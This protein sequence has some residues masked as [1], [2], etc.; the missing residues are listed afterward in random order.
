MPISQEGF[1]KENLRNID[2]IKLV[3]IDNFG[4]SVFTRQQ[5]LEKM[6]EKYPDVPEGS[7]LMSDYC[8]NTVSGGEF[9]NEYR[10]LFRVKQGEYRLY[11]PYRDGK[12]KKGK[13]VID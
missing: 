10:F 9:S 11:D 13:Q 7:I 2:K 3:V 6:R 8:V 4:A 12:W 5:L 1:E